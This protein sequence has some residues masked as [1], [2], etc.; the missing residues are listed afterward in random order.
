MYY[1]VYNITNMYVYH[2]IIMILLN[3]IMFS[4]V[5]YYYVSAVCIVAQFGNIFINKITMLQKTLHACMYLH[6]LV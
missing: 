4:I 1:A 6:K 5:C 3:Y 2:N